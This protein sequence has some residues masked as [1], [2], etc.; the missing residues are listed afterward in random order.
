MTQTWVEWDIIRKIRCG[1]R[2][3]NIEFKG[4]KKKKG[5]TKAKEKEIRAQKEIKNVTQVGSSS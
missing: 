1:Q 3:L 4:K 2:K 5:A